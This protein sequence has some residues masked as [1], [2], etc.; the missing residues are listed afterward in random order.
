MVPAR[1][2]TTVST[3]HTNHPVYTTLLA[4]QFLTDPLFNYMFGT[5]SV[6]WYDRSPAT[7]HLIRLQLLAASYKSRAI[8]YSGASSPKPLAPSQAEL[9]PQC[10]AVIM[11][12]GE[13]TMALGLLGW[14]SM[15]THGVHKLVR[16]AG[17]S[18]WNTFVTEYVE[19][20]ARLKATVFR[21]DETYFYVFYIATDARHRGKGLAQAVIGELQVRA[22]KEM[23]PVW[24][25]ASSPASRRVYAKCGFEDVG[26][27][28]RLGVGEVDEF[29]DKVGKG[30]VGVPLFPMVWWP[31][32]YLKKVV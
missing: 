31:V 29:G 3:T 24:L 21:P 5:C 8:F 15:L 20:V 19:P 14:A 9:N 6:P 26:E 7:Y 4:K 28:M 1:Q 13:D 17:F 23:R 18:G 10:C 32:G 25:E 30:G 22:Q 11:P 2:P 27:E 12:P 16:L